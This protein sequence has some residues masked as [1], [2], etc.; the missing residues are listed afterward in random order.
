MTS[1]EVNLE[2]IKT[3]AH[4]QAVLRGLDN[5]KDVKIHKDVR[6]ILDE[7][8]HVFKAVEKHIVK[9]WEEINKLLHNIDSEIMEVIIEAYQFKINEVVDLKISDVVTIKD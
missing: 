1:E 3:L 8:K 9:D 6:S 2:L 7:S 4:V 5:L